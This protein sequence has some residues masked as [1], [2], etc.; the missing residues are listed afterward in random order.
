MA[1]ALKHIQEDIKRWNRVGKIAE[2]LELIWGK[3]WGNKEIFHFEWHP[4]MPS[5]I[6][7]PTFKRMMDLCGPQLKHY[8][9]AWDLFKNM[10]DK[11]PS[12]TPSDT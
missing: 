5:A 3:Q 8:Q 1:D 12:S 11:M 10:T 2:E 9:S 6:R 7:A 4:N